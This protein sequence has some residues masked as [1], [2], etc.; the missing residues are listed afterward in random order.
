MTQGVVEL[1]PKPPEAVEPVVTT[2]EP[3]RKPPVGVVK[4]ASMLPEP[5]EVRY[6]L[7]PQFVPDVPE[8]SQTTIGAGALFTEMVVDGDAPEYPQ[9]FEATT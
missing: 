3:L 4:C 9:A 8:K 5:V 2:D 6:G 1:P 7:A